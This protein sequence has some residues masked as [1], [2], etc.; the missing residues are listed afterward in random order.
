[1]LELNHIWFKISSIHEKC[2]EFWWLNFCS[3][4][5]EL[6]LSYK[7]LFF[8]LACNFFCRSMEIFIKCKR[9]SYSEIMDLEKIYRPWKNK[10]FAPFFGVFSHSR[11]V[12]DEL[13]ITRVLYIQ[14]PEL[15]SIATN[16]YEMP[17]PVFAGQNHWCK[18]LLSTWMISA[19]M[20][21]V[22]Y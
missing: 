21:N 3:F 14:G 5:A 11:I 13:S 10:A 17:S 12:T 22:S 4:L 16:D 6:Q 20:F 15:E 7:A 18:S 1:M 2:D 8:V 9:S 19:C